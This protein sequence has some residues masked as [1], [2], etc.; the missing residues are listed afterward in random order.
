MVV[1]QQRNAEDLRIRQ[2]SAGVVKEFRLDT[3][4]ATMKLYLESIGPAR[5]NG[6]AHSY[7]IPHEP[8]QQMA[9]MFLDH[10]FEALA[11]VPTVRK[12]LAERVR[13]LGSTNS[14][15]L[16]FYQSLVNSA[17]DAELAAAI[18]KAR[19]SIDKLS[20]RYER[21]RENFEAGKPIKIRNTFP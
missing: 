10:K 1:A 16:G 18:E 6:Y 7:V 19:Y 11:L 2:I 14:N 21:A 9:K 8:E 13:F 20:G 15:E 5:Q 4:L 3:Y 12:E 17:S